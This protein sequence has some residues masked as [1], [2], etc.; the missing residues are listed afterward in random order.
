MS[1]YRRCRWVVMCACAVLVGSALVVFAQGRFHR[2]HTATQAQT[3]ELVAADQQP[4]IAAR[5]SVEP[6]GDHRHIEANA[7]P[8]HLVGRFPNRGNPN[9]I[10]AQRQRLRL[11]LDPAIADEVTPLVNSSRYGPPGM[12][13]GVAV[14]GVQ[15][16]PGAAEWWLRNRLSGWT[17]EPL[18]GAVPLGLDENHAHVQPTG[19]YHYHGLPAGLLEELGHGSDHH[20]P[21]VG[22]A[23]DG[24]PVYAVYGFAE[25]NDAD[26]DAVAL[27]SSYRL[28]AGER[29]GGSEPGGEFDGA[30]VEDYEYVAGSGDLDECNGRHCVTPEFPDGTYAYFLTRDW[31]VIPRNFRGTPVRIR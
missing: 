10:R 17:Y 2:R 7:V 26:S 29:P 9:A 19:K 8:G 11:P 24:F 13:F 23:A 3:L 22:W 14:N 12:P 4:P 15:F 1:P 18:G 21:L 31:P 20:S 5:V 28:R 6:R 27:C 25:P 30:F 16:D